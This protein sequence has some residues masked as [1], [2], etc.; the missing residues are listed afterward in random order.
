M[1]YANSGIFGDVERFSPDGNKLI[2]SESRV[3]GCG[4]LLRRWIVDIP[5]GLYI[6]PLSG[7]AS[8]FSPNGQ[9]VANYDADGTD[10]SYF[11]ETGR[12]IPDFINLGL[13]VYDTSTGDPLFQDDAVFTG[14]PRWTADGSALVLDHHDGTFTVFAVQE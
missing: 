5:T 1:F 9:L 11:D 4:G 6:A 2:L 8:A 7:S 13:T 12:Y 10:V 14:T 3:T